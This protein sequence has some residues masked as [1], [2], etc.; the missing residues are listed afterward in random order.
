MIKSV[1]HIL[2]FLLPFNTLFAQR[3][4]FADSCLIA[5]YPPQDK[6]IS[7]DS[8]YSFFKSETFLKGFM[9]PNRMYILNDTPI[10][11][12]MILKSR[13]IPVFVSNIAFSPPITPKTGFKE[14][15]IKIGSIT[16]RYIAST[17]IPKEAYIDLFSRVIDTTTHYDKPITHFTASMFNDS[18]NNL[19]LYNVKCNVINNLAPMPPY[20][21]KPKNKRDEGYISAKRELARR[22]REISISIPVFDSTYTYAFVA[23]GYYE[24]K[25][26]LLY[27]R[28]ADGWILLMA[29]NQNYISSR[30]DGMDF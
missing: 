22:V 15:S 26:G 14:D 8:V 19:L 13:D 9:W 28:E 1:I 20:R 10:E 30:I 5:A 23:I 6:V 29:G 21:Y 7:T 3:Y 24:P 2:F 4:W 12:K 18:V 17:M 25:I 11:Q 16:R 27:R